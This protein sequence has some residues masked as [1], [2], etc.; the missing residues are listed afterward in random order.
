MMMSERRSSTQMKEHEIRNFIPKDQ[1]QIL[2]KI[3]E[4]RMRAFE[5]RTQENITK[6]HMPLV[7]DDVK[8]VMV[9][10]Y[11]VAKNKLKDN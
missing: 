11:F 6:P 9:Q 7:N 2:D 8:Q 5:D 10:D 4:M 3:H 1:D